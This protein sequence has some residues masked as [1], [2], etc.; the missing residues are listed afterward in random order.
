MAGGMTMKVDAQR[1]NRELAKFVRTLG[2]AAVDVAVRGTAFHVG[3]DIVRSLNGYDAGFPAPK[4]IDTARYRAGWV[5]GVAQVAP[6][7]QDSTEGGD[8]DNPQRSDD[9]VGQRI[10]TSGGNKLVLRV[11]NNVEYGPYVEHGTETMAP[12]NHMRLALLR[13]AVRLREAIGEAIPD[14]WANAVTLGFGGAA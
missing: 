12:G 11:T 10:Q 1:L 14:A 5:M 13:G 7:A 3:G 2:P 9:G 6:P 4:R 8:A